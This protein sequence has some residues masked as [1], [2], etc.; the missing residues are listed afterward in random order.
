MIEINFKGKNIFKFRDESFIQI[1][2]K[3]EEL[4]RLIVDVYLKIFSGYKFSDIDMEAMK[5]FYPEVTRDGQT[6]KKNDIEVIRIS[7]IEDVLEQLKV[8]KGSI[9]LEHLLSLNNELT[10]NKALNNIEEGLMQ[11]SI[12]L[13]RLIQDKVASD[14]ISIET[15]ICNFDF[16]KIVASFI[17]INY[18]DEFGTSKPL[19][20]LNGKEYL[21]LFLNLIK[22]RL[23]DNVCMTII[24]DG[25]D[26]KMAKDL[27]DNFINELY[28][29]TKEY[30]NFKIWLIPKTK[31]G[32]LLDYNIFNNTYIIDDEVIS[33]KD[34]GVTYDSICRNYPDNNFPMEKEVLESI[35]TLFPF[36][37]DSIKYSLSK[38]TV[39]LKVF[40][41]LLDRDLTNIENTKLS[42]LE[43][44]FLTSNI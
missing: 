24:I 7:N 26:V 8:K 1:V 14:N 2:G 15:D 5:G 6:L 12:Q 29:L 44:K 28:C 40:L 43:T 31:E 32:V 33:L 38:E 20:L 19:W 42:Q 10:I 21:D 11:L 9:I 27:Y 18:V 37:N 39:I 3:N 17:E 23:K 30:S 16:K 4:K 13:D 22:L 34:F 35:L 41:K 36:Y 25:L